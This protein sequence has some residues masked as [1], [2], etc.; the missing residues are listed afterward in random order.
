[1]LYYLWR[2]VRRGPW[3]DCVHEIRVI[4]LCLN[5]SVCVSLCVCVRAHARAC[6]C[7]GGMRSH[8]WCDTRK[9]LNQHVNKDLCGYVQYSSASVMPVCY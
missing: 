5:V 6:L 8:V 2:G 9:Y 1:M 4:H 7:F 3:G